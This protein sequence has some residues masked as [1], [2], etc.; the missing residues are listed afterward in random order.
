M[1]INSSCGALR[2]LYL[3]QTVSFIHKMF[4]L[5]K[6]RVIKFIS[7]F[8]RF[9]TFLYD[10]HVTKDMHNPLYNTFMKYVH[11]LNNKSIWSGI[12]ILF[13]FLQSLRHHD[14]IGI[15]TR[16]CG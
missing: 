7:R 10:W 14:S 4:L 11:K 12:N 15:V 3:A 2:I 6:V 13:H 16:P 1:Y 5:E 9:W 8:I